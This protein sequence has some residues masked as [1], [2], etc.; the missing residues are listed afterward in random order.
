M[1]IVLLHV[2]EF[3][4][5]VFV[6]FSLFDSHLQSTF[7]IGKTLE[8]HV[9][10]QPYRRIHCARAY[11]FHGKKN[12]MSI[13]SMCMCNMPQPHFCVFI[14]RSAHKSKQMENQFFPFR[15]V[16]KSRADVL[17]HLHLWNRKKLVIKKQTWCK[18]DRRWK[19]LS[20]MCRMCVVLYYISKSRSNT[21]WKEKQS[22]LEMEGKRDPP[23]INC[24]NL[25]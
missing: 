8:I 12:R 7:S 19:T 14:A 6:T 20:P 25:F 13:V 9:I 10:A 5:C 23:K 18:V 4:V 1:H 16:N 17:S 22:R 15:A 21:S 3:D 11:I 24:I 2:F